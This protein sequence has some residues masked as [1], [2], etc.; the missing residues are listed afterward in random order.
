MKANEFRIGNIVCDQ[1]GLVGNIITL[2]KSAVLVKME[3]STTKTDYKGIYPIEITE[4][5]LLRFGFRTFDGT[6]YGLRIGNY[7]IQ[8][9]YYDCWNLTIESDNEKCELQNYWA[10]HNLQNIIFEITGEELIAQ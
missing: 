8:I 5:W 9:Y 2:Y 1:L 3:F 10:V 4:E 7:H 6:I